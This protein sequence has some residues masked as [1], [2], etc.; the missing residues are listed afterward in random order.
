[1]GRKAKHTQEQVFA[2]ADE[3]AASGQEVTAT[4]LQ[5]A[6]GGSMTTIYKHLDEWLTK[7]AQEDAPLPVEMP[8]NV[9]ASF[10]NAWQVASQE[11]SK[12]V[13]VI[14]EKADSEVKALTKRAEEAR[15]TI[16]R[17]E[18][19]A[20]KD[21]ARIEMLEQQVLDTKRAADLA[22]TEAEKR[23]AVLTATVEQKQQH[24]EELQLL[25]QRSHDE[26]QVFRQD[27]ADE[28]SR[29][30]IDFMR[31]LDE[32]TEA[33]R[34]AGSEVVN[35]RGKLDEA[36]TQLASARDETHTV[37][38]T[39]SNLQ[40]RLKDSLEAL[41]TANEKATDAVAQI[42][43]LSGKCEALRAQVQEQSKLLQSF[44]EAKQKT[45]TPG[46]PKTKP[47]PPTDNTPE[48]EK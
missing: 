43:N 34:L 9:L 46:K 18:V 41:A 3:I 13:A 21:E 15:K 10:S 11:A 42:S 25:L 1:M 17:L 6:L 26:H 37:T 29:L 19:E 30:T 36:V 33:L 44:A 4:V 16:E 23:E 22:V 14:R 45:I 40:G 48:A 28:H 31:R 32:Q 5:A 38:A 47:K 12:E 2:A 8:A 35:L 24:I 27:K 7:R 20:E 39:I